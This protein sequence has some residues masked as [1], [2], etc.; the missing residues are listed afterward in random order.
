MKGVNSMPKKKYSDEL[1]LEIVERYLKE[2]ISAKQ[3]AKEYYIGSEAD[4]KKWIAMYEHHGVRG[5]CTV[6]GS[7]ASN[8]KVSVVE[9]MQNTGASIRQ[10][11][12]YFNIPFPQTVALW[13]R[14]YNTEGKEALCEERRGRANKMN[15][16]KGKKPQDNKKEN[17]DILAELK[18]LRMENEYL[19]KLNALIQE[20]E[21]S[22]NTT[23]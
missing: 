3:L 1:K 8:F 2:N 9:Y 7:Y 14:I 16:K 20:R 21:K 15:S 19:K 6:N 4:I 23:K 17:E 10:T 11:A 22:Q 12:A 13:Q 5:L 18:R